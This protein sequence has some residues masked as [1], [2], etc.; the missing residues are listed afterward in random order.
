M[1]AEAFGR[2]DYAC[3]IGPFAAVLQLGVASSNLAIGPLADRS[4]ALAFTAMTA[5]NLLG[6][7]AVVLALKKKPYHGTDAASASQ[8][9]CGAG[10]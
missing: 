8:A 5:V 4:Y 9:A 10:K 7:F 2:R 6:A 1:V 3:I